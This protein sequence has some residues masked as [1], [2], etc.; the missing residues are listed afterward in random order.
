MPSHPYGK[1]FYKCVFLLAN[2][3]TPRGTVRFA[4]YQD[5]ASGRKSSRVSAVFNRF[6]PFREIRN[7]KHE[8]RNKRQ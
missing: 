3:R 4:L 7:P 8:I 5:V 6:P 1:H 2:G